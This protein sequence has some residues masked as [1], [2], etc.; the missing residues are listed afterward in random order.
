MR[1][2]LLFVVWLG[3]LACSILFARLRHWPG[4]EDNLNATYFMFSLLSWIGL[5][6][7]AIVGSLLSM[8]NVVQAARKSQIYLIRSVVCLVLFL[9]SLAAGILI[10]T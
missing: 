6:L 5:G 9:V 1:I 7:L 3:L 10:N 8:Y 4:D 2:A